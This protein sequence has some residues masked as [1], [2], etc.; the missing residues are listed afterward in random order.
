MYEIASAASERA[1]AATGA[2]KRAAGLLG[3]LH[4]ATDKNHSIYRTRSVMRQ[5]DEH[6]LKQ[7]IQELRQ[8]CGMT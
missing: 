5:I 4:G 6:Y 8:R 3:R 2:A 7:S 1:G